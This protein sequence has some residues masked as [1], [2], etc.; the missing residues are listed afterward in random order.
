MARTAHVVLSRVNSCLERNRNFEVET[1]NVVDV[2]VV[3]GLKKRNCMA[4]ET[5]PFDDDHYCLRKEI[6]RHLETEL[7]HRLQLLDCYYW[8][9]WSGVR[10]IIRTPK[11]F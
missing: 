9:A 2:A 10:R 3:V 7:P 6:G 5:T 1:E 4:E 8:G 11:F